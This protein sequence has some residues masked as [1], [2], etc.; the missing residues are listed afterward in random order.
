MVVIMNFAA[1]E[2]HSVNK[3]LLPRFELVRDAT[4]GS[5]NS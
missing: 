1:P 4:I 3:A 2:A 5:D